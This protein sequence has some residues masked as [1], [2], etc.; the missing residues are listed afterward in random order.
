MLLKLLCASFL[1]LPI[2]IPS[3]PAGP[4]EVIVSMSEGTATVVAKILYAVLY[5]FL[6][7]VVTYFFA[8][9]RR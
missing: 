6:C 1:Q 8:T 9:L 4:Q 3:P 5:H 7:L 2:P